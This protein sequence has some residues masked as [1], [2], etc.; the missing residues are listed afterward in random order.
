MMIDEYRKF[1]STPRWK[2][3][4]RVALD[5]DGWRC[6]QCGKA[7]RLEVD[8]IQPMH[9]GGAFWDLDNLQSLCVSCHIAETARENSRRRVALMTPE[10]Q[11]WRSMV[12]E[13]ANM[14]N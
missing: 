8:H 9:K 4:R 5:R 3:L 13:L 2:R 6:R 10:R 7:G 11:A 12:D 1:Y 14:S